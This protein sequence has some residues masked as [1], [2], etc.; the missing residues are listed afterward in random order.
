MSNPNQQVVTSPYDP[1]CELCG[2]PADQLWQ[3]DM[4]ICNPCKQWIE[5]GAPLE[6]TDSADG[7][8]CGGLHGCGCE[9]F[10]DVVGNGFPSTQGIPFP[11]SLLDAFNLESVDDFPDAP[12]RP[13]KMLTIGDMLV[14]PPSQCPHCEAIQTD[15]ILGSYRL[16]ESQIEHVECGECGGQW[17]WM[18]NQAGL[19][20]HT[21]TFFTVCPHCRGVPNLERVV[22]GQR[23][24]K[25]M[26]SLKMMC[27]CGTEI[28][29][30]RNMTDGSEEIDLFY[31][32]NASESRD[33]R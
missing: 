33:G 18:R 26:R 7:C 5:A 2:A 19:I 4:H 30:L 29:V 9:S 12:S 3:S 1:L 8:E 23:R 22:Y 15:T 31:T 16:H 21:E 11:D 28:Q 20:T 17:Q 6:K 32:D 10:N 24:D 14:L 27:D 25:L 13:A